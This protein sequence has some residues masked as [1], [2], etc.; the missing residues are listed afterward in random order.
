[1]HIYKYLLLF[2]LINQSFSLKS[3]IP[4]TTK[5]QLVNKIEEVLIT[6]GFQNVRVGE[7]AA[8]VILSYENS[9]YR[10]EV[11]ALKNV[12]T[13]IAPLVEKQLLVII[14][15]KQDI[16]LLVTQLKI[17][18]YRAFNN[19]EIT[20]EQFFDQ[21]ILDQNH[22]YLKFKDWKNSNTNTG[23]FRAEL[24]IAPDL[25][26]AYG[27]KPDAVLHQFNIIPNLNVYLWKG[28]ALKLQTI[29]PISNELEIP[30]EKIIRPGLLTFHQ[31]VRLPH[32]AFATIS[33]GYFSNYRY[34]SRLNVTKYLFNGRLTLQGQAG[35][36]GYAAY[37][38]RLFLSNDTP[39]KAWEYA[40][41][42]YWDYQAK[43]S[44]LFPKYNLFV[45]LTYGKVLD[46]DR[47][48]QV[49]INQ[50]FKELTVGFFAYKVDKG[51]NYG[52]NLKI[53]FFPKKYLLHFKSP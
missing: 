41:L 9:V 6:E 51:T 44:Y 26:I 25:N 31:R 8:A 20:T 15:K 22:P 47:F 4:P 35:N 52:V 1:M 46:N 2:L 43:A 5:S 28:A 38:K 19:K 45:D 40:A 12:I 50:Q 42:G 24:E 18:D 29:F 11:A 27:A 23:Q 48:Y 30:E 17:K 21:L 34:G 37:P 33:L 3:Q 10:Y 39:E 49:T 53:P 36:T 7:D 16:P 14:T 32:N 13:T